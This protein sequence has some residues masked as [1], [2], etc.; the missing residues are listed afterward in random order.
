MP[1]RQQRT[2][3]TKRAPPAQGILAPQRCA[4]RLGYFGFLFRVGE[5]PETEYE[6]I[7]PLYEGTQ[8][9]HEDFATFRGIV[10]QEAFFSGGIRPNDRSGQGKT[11]SM[12]K[13]SDCREPS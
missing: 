3:T 10:K 13:R 12:R 11:L 2:Q 8:V 1:F 4:T 9:V 5:L 6:F 7:H